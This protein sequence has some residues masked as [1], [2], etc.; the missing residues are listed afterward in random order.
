MTDYES[1]R[2][3]IEK[4]TQDPVQIK[5]QLY[6]YALSMGDLEKI[7]EMHSD[8]VPVMLEL[9]YQSI[10]FKQLPIFEYLI[11]EYKEK[12]GVVP[13]IIGYWVARAGIK[14]CEVYNSVGGVFEIIQEAEEESSLMTCAVC[15]ND[16]DVVKLVFSQVKK[17]SSGAEELRIA[18]S[19][20][21]EE[22]VKWCKENGAIEKDLF[23]RYDDASLC[24]DNI[25]KICD[26]EDKYEK[27]MKKL[28][29]LDE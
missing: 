22:M 21:N 9:I 1:I 24:F 5:G 8:G 2:K 14:W 20:K 23:G 10:Q 29:E 6:C 26:E 18:H 3:E 11:K 27:E 16:L 7:K 12:N 17:W 13:S 28:Q 4:E 15:T 25:K 19:K